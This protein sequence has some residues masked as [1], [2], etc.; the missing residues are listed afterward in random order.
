[1]KA[2]GSRIRLNWAV[3]SSQLAVKT[4]LIITASIG[5]IAIIS[6]VATRQTAHFTNR[7]VSSS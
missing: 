2:I 3:E 7:K 1:M 6:E 5:E 4:I